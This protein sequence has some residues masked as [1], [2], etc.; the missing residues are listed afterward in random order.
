MARSLRSQSQSC[1]PAITDTMS[2][3]K[4]PP[5]F[6]AQVLDKLDQLK[7]VPS[8]MKQVKEDLA[9]IIKSNEEFRQSLDL[10]HNRLDDHDRELRRKDGEIITLKKNLELASHR[11]SRLTSQMSELERRFNLQESYS[12]RH[13]II[14]EGLPEAQGEDTERRAFHLMADTMKLPIAQSDIDKCHRFGRVINNRPKPII[15][16][17]IAHSTRDKVLQAARRCPH[18]PESVFLN[19]D[20]PVPLKKERAVLRQTAKHAE[21]TGATVKLAG[22]RLMVNNLSYTY[23]SLHTLPHE[24]SLFSARTRKTGDCMGFYSE[25]SFLSNFFKS[26]FQVDNRTYPTMEHYFQT[27][28]CQAAGRDDLVNQINVTSDCAAVKS[29]GDSVP[30]RDLPQDWYAKQEPI[31]K[32]GLVAKFS[33]SADLKA[34]L[35]QSGSATLVE[36][37]SNKFWGGD[38]KLSSEDLRTQTY[39]GRNKLGKLLMDVRTELQ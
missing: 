38:C 1:V 14:I 27:M 28:R 21:S 37:T 2:K 8:D 24:F 30:S 19:E 13:N 23:K 39:S 16:R 11:N 34:K 5:S 36:C 26:D 31:M 15:V 17:C 35:I 3:D 33:Q 22:D 10:A 20:L 4:E 6:E 25:F 32:A 12:K 7:A 9:V 18:K 29:V